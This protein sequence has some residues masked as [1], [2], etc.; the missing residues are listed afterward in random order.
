[1]VVFRI[2]GILDVEVNRHSDLFTL[3]LDIAMT[4]TA[5]RVMSLIMTLHNKRSF[6]VNY[7]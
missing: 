7:L 6:I 4:V 1:M 2:G 3:V 5:Y